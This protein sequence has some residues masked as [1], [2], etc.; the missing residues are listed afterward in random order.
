MTDIADE[1]LDFEVTL[2]IANRTAGTDQLLERLREKN[3]A[4]QGH[5]ASSSSCR[6]TTASAT[7]PPPPARGSATC[8]TGCARRACSRPGMIGDPDPYVATMNAL[9]FYTREHGRHLDAARGALRLAAPGPHRARAQGVEHR[10]E[11]VV[12]ERGA[13]ETAA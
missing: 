10:L 11:H 4:A 2:V 12:A 8:W 13:A 6:W 9:Q 7:R 3:E 5:D 1:G